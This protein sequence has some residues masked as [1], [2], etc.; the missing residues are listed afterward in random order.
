M[1]N[2]K[3]AKKRAKQNSVKALE[4]KVKRT[5]AKT[6]IIKLKKAIE[7]KDKDTAVK[8]LRDVQSLLSRASKTRAIAKNAASRKT[9]RLA[10]R[11]QAI[12]G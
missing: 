9:S 12:L 5:M 6:A 3:S 1:A 2:H 4:N 7:G 8:C 10:Q 11:V